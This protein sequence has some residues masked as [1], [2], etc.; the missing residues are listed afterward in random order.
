[1]VLL[2]PSYIFA[3]MYFGPAAAI[4]QDLI[5]P[6]FRGLGTAFY[7]IVISL[8]ALSPLIV[9]ALNQCFNIVEQGENPDAYDPTYSLLIVV[10]GTYLLSSVG[11]LITSF[12][13]RSHSYYLSKLLQNEKEDRPL[14]R[15]QSKN[16]NENEQ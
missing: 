4:V 12:L 14:L 10:P 15:S 16:E 6:S 3:E 8:G 13:C 5:P 1:M 2:F 9:G 11:F 7:F